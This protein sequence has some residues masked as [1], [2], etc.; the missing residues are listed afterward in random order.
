MCSRDQWL[1]CARMETRLS[2]IFVDANSWLIV[3]YNNVN[4]LNGLIEMMILTFRLECPSWGELNKHAE[5]AINSLVTSKLHMEPLGMR[6][7]VM[8]KLNSSWSHSEQVYIFTQ[9]FK[10][11][12]TIVHKENL[13]ICETPRHARCHDEV[14]LKSYELHVTRRINHELHDGMT[15][16]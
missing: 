4:S 10:R 9:V 12:V 16:S 5:K 11:P 13:S 14:K 1:Y 3:D 7:V 15:T 2:L 8:G 6:D